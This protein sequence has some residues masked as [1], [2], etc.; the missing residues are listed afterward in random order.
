MIATPTAAHPC[1][2][3]RRFRSMQDIDSSVLVQIGYDP[4]QRE[5][6]AV[7]R[8]SGRRYAYEG[9]PVEEYEALLCAGSIDAWFNRRIRDRYPC[10]EILPPSA[11]PGRQSSRDGRSEHGHRRFLRR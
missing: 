1:A 4:E 9:A 5:L 10:H 3:V 7:F 6:I 8:A 2:V 11:P